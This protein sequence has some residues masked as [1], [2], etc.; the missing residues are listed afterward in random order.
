M[1]IVR[2]EAYGLG[3]GEDAQGNI[4]APLIF[5]LTTMPQGEQTL[6]LSNLS[7]SYA[8]DNLRLLSSSTYFTHSIQFFN[9][10]DTYLTSPAATVLDTHLVYTDKNYSQELRLSNTGQG[11]WL[12]MIGGFYKHYA[13]SNSV[14]ELLT[15]STTPTSAINIDESGLNTG[16]NSAAAFANASYRLTPRLT[17]GAGV[18]HYTA[19]ETYTF[20]LVN[21]NGYAGLGV[22]PGKS[23]KG[24][25][26]STDPRYF[27]QYRVGSHVNTY[28]SAS[29]GFREGGFNSPGLPTYQ[30]ETV[31]R[32]DAGLKSRY[33]QN[34]LQAN[35]DVFYSDYTNY[36]I[37]G[38]VPTANQYYEANAGKAHIKGVIPA[39]KWRL[40]GAWN[41]GVSAEYTDAEFVILSL[42]DTGYAVGDRVPF[43]TKYSFSGSVERDFSWRDHRGYAIVSYSE[44]SDVQQRQVGY[45]YPLFSS[46]VMHYLS[47]NSS[48]DL[49]PNLSVGLFGSNLL[50]D[51]GYMDP[52]SLYGQ[53]SRPQPRTFG[54]DFKVNFGG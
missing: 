51:R 2:R 34:S 3:W 27:V 23:E 13:D 17:I 52:L 19:H 16:A 7:V 33:L 32:Y 35:L 14:A 40:S 6:N 31:W 49:N 30:P 53:A 5:G 41:V 38:F 43:T 11:P 20:P 24:S 21:Y 54:I 26:N 1:Q 50:N 37:T 47:F 44:I 25:F 36:V 9:G 28:A 4:A 22:I 39:I 48:V 42:L 18:R 29:K 15:Y 10:L 12:W 45:I 46:A 8:I